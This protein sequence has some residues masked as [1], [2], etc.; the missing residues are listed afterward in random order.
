MFDEG[1]I[2]MYGYK[3]VS[4]TCIEIQ[5]CISMYQ[6]YIKTIDYIYLVKTIYRQILVYIKRHSKKFRIVQ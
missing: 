4:S 5:G 3:D 1:C 2:S 6:L